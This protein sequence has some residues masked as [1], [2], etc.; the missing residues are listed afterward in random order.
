MISSTGASPGSACTRSGLSTSICARL[1]CQD[2]GAKLRIKWRY[3]R[4]RGVIIV[5]RKNAAISE[6]Q[7]AAVV[8]NIRN[9]SG[10]PGEYRLRVAIAQ[11]PRG[12]VNC[13]Q[14]GAACQYSMQKRRLC[15]IEAD[16]PAR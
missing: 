15:C 10:R 2:Y 1:T 4:L 13:A 14:T 12:G 5:K 3:L 8:H 11:P 7:A 16:M 6:A 9:L